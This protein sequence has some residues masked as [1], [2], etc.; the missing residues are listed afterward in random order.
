MTD[1]GQQGTATKP[2]QLARQGTA[3]KPTEQ[4]LR[5]RPVQE[6]SARRVERILDACAEL[7]AEL[8]YE[9]VTTTA[10]AGR[11]QVAIGTLYQFFP[12]KRAVVRALTRRYLDLFLER[13]S[14]R[15]ARETITHWWVAVDAALDEYILMH[16]TVTGFS[17]LHFGD[18]VDVNLLDEASENNNVIADQLANLLADRLEVE[19]SAELR[20]A[21]LV[22]VE[23]A[24]AVLTLAFRRRPAGDP[25]LIAATKELLH[26]YLGNHLP[27]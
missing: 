15:F 8:G 16:Q 27:D 20:L 21:L 2:A 14:E 12:D 6:R 26:A 7:V 5:R 9:R 18:V 23:A 25:D 19:N 11:A 13:L 10:I 4:S 3:I 24:D 22:S 1:R 17:K